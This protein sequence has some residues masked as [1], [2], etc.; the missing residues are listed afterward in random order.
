[1]PIDEAKNHLN[2]EISKRIESFRLRRRNYRTGALAYALGSSVLAIGTS[3]S[4]ALGKFFNAD[5]WTI[6]ALLM[7]AILSILSVWDAFFAHRQRWIQTNETLM[8]L[9][10]LRSDLNFERAMGGALNE[11]FVR[12]IYRRYTQILQEANKGWKDLRSDQESGN[13]TQAKEA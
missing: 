12:E 1:M 4:I 9:Y 5:A 6:V 10:E 3:V 11:E 2:T 7:S 8:R 13:S